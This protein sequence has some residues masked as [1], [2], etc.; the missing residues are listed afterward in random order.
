M[1]FYKNFYLDILVDGILGI[2]FAYVI[3]SAFEKQETRFKYL[4]IFSGEIMLCL[5]KTSGIGLAVLSMFIIFI[6]LIIE[7]NKNNKEFFREIKYLI[8][9]ILITFFLTSIWYMKVSDMQK[10]WDFSRYLEKE[11]Q[12]PEIQENITENFI[13]TIVFKQIITERNFTVLTT[14]LLLI[15]LQVYTATKVKEE[16]Y[17]YYSLAMILSILIYLIGLFITYS[18]IFDIQEAQI[19]TSFERYTSSILLACV[20]FQMMVLS[21]VKYDKDLK[22]IIVTLSILL[23]LI[24][25]KNIQEKY[26]NGNNYIVT[27]NINREIYTKLKRYK[28]KLNTTDKILFICG[29]KANMEY[30]KAMNEYEIM[31]IKI[32]Q[33]LTGSFTNLQSFESIIK[34][35]TYVYI[36]RIDEEEISKIEEIFQYNYVGNDI[37][38]KVNKYDN[39]ILLEIVMK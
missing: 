19:L 2:M 29:S 20:M 18:K 32:E 36:Y 1:I 25:M 14:F 22:S 28:D 38:Y 7:K 5:T 23:V 39:E 12:M 21:Q 35:Y 11:E 17:K 9:I 30:L 13:Y 16:N 10:R 26:I 27:S 37:L 24:P 31:P 3:Y 6:K 15:C 34:D 8:V 33:I 4:K